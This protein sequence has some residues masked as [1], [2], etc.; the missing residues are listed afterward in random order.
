MF[1][2][3]LDKMPRQN[4]T[5]APVPVINRPNDVQAQPIT[6]MLNL[7][8]IHILYDHSVWIMGFAGFEEFDE[9]HARDYTRTSSY[10]AY[11]LPK[12]LTEIEPS[13]PGGYGSGDRLALLP[14]APSG[15][16]RL[17]T[18]IRIRVTTPG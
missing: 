10:G 13:P 11:A 12:V 7:Q 8:E 4:I 5:Q 3:K 9:R 17:A 6:E 15:I 16:L 18:V 2:A 1:K 14:G